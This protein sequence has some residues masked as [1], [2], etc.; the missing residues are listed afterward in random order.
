MKYKNLYLGFV[1]ISVLAITGAFFITNSSD[2]DDIKQP[3]DIP[4]NSSELTLGQISN[5]NTPEA[6]Q[7]TQPQTNGL[8]VQAAD[9]QQQNNNQNQ[10]PSPDE[11]S[12][13]EEYSESESPLY[14]DTVIG[15]GK[16][17]KKGD[18]VAMLYKGY[19][20]NGQIF[21]E[22]RLNDENQIEAFGFTLGSGQVIQGWDTTITGMK[23]GGSRR[24]IIPAQFGYGPS[25]QGSIPPNSMLIFDVELVA[26][27]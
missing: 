25:A 2:Q 9:T 24:L 26:V 23:V 11:F 14:I 16:E 4:L 27:E 18:N 15:T 6:A 7:S 21:D 12:V 8:S 19:L 13:Y 1:F 20:T 3:K 17:A 10:L 5:Q 22:S